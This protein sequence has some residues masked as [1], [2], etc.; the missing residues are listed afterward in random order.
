M[1]TISAKQERSTAYDYYV[2]GVLALIYMFSSI[3]RTLISVLA[4]PIK[5]EFGLGDAQL[6]LLTGLAFAISY[7]LAGIPLGLMVDRFRRTRLLASLVAV[8]SLLTFLSGFATSAFTLALARIGVGASESGASPASMSLITD[9]FPKERRGFALSLFYMSTPI[10]LGISFIV[11]GT[12]AATFG[13]RGA[14]FVAGGPGLLLAL[15]VLLTIREPVRGRYDEYDPAAAKEKYQFREAAQTLVAIRPLLLLMFAAVSVTIAQAGLGAFMSPFLIR[16]HDLSVEEAG[17]AIGLAKSST[18]IAGILIGGILADRM[19]KR[20]MHAAPLAVGLLISLAAPFAIAAMLV[21]DWRMAIGLVA[22]YNFF[23]YT[24]YG[25]TFATYMSLAPVHMRGALAGMLAVVLS[26]VG[27]GFGPPFTGITSDLLAGAG[28]AEPLRW[29]LA[30][31]ALF[32]AVAGLLFLAAAAS[33][34]RMDRT[35]AETAS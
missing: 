19:A 26:M 9:Y 29:A 33:I 28:V 7:T 14:F 21:A 2:V 24:Y 15:L 5:L 16:V 17:F 13:W 23:N 34:Q 8:W 25:A 18:G 27:Y 32:F 3:D 6:G 35:E 30:A 20:S 31:T 22:V 4:E 10:A 1:A 11:G 12:L